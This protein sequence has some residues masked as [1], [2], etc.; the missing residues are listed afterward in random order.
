[1]QL[2]CIISSH[3][4]R[5]LAFADVRV[6]KSD[7]DVLAGLHDIVVGIGHDRVAPHDQIDCEGRVVGDDTSEHIDSFR[8]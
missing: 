5:E 6:F 7:G 1:M 4:T 3:F 8:S 2:R